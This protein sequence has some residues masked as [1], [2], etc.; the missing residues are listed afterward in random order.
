[1]AKLLQAESRCDTG[2]APTRRHLISALDL[3]LQPEMINQQL[4]D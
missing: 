4:A 1:M 2:T 3:L